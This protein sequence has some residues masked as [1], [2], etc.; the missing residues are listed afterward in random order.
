MHSIIFLHYSQFA[1]AVAARSPS[2][3]TQCRST[4]DLNRIAGHVCTCFRTQEQYQT[5]KVA[6]LANTTCGLSG[7]KSPGVLLKSEVCHTT[8]KHAR[9]N[10]IDHDVLGG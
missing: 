4:I 9:A 3:S 2:P 1:F 8:G 7:S 5:T 6:G 10:D